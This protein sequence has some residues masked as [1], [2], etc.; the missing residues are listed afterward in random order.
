MRLERFRGQNVPS[1]LIKLRAQMGDDALLL[2][3]RSRTDGV[4][5]VATT[6]A[7][8]RRFG[9]ALQS[10]PVHRRPGRR[11]RVIALVGP[12]GAGK[13]TTIAKLSLS[14]IAFGGS[15]VGVISL[16][17]YKI[18]AFDQIQIYADLG[19]LELEVLQ[20]AS[21][22]PGALNRMKDCDVILV[23]TPGRTLRATA[24]ESS[25][26]ATLDALQP[27]E[28]HLVVSAG[29]RD[30]VA[31]GVRGHYAGIGLTHLLLTKLEEVPGQLGVAQ[32]ADRLSLPTRWVTDG[33]SVPDDLHTAPEL[34]LQAAVNGPA[35]EW[36]LE[37]IA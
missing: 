27:D 7:E 31:D 2:H 14:D 34:L 21:E 26:R 11:S 3:T 29:L 33:Q 37:A 17:T 22:V 4:E 28:V 19:D 13:T 23:D 24:S 20:D 1:A 18:G 36:R 32:L 8:I 10:P 16:D 6:E 25:W 15:R 30:V 5:I 9:D 35:S 12:T